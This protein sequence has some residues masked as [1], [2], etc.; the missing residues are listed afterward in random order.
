MTDVV[1]NAQ[2][3]PIIRPTAFDPPTRLGKLREQQPLSRLRFADGH[4]GWLVTNQR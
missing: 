1:V 3:L 2:P 4:V